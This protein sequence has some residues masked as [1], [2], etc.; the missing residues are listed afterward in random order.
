MG[1]ELVARFL[2]VNDVPQIYCTSSMIIISHHPWCV[3]SFFHTAKKN[4][5]QIY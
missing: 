3:R 5:P 1:M 4:E 2:K